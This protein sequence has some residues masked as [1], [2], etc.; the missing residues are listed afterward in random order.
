VFVPL[1]GLVGVLRPAK[2]DSRWHR[3]RQAR[4]T[5]P[6]QVKPPDEERR[7]TAGSRT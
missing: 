3:W 1:V 2:P 5:S 4:S 7:P 6:D